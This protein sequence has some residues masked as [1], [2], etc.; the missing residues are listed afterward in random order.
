[1]TP[2]LPLGASLASLL[3][4]SVLL[5]IHDFG[6]VTLPCRFRVY[7]G[8]RNPISP[9]HIDVR[10]NFF[11]Q[12]T[13]CPCRLQTGLLLSVWMGIL[14]LLLAVGSLAASADPIVTLTVATRLTA[15]DGDAYDSFG[16]PV[17]IHE[18]LV[19]VGAS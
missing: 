7:A 6:K 19:A 15:P 4:L 5:C 18:K 9:Y 14:V 1:M 11:M 10:K 8:K 12:R 2:V 16:Y 3:L 17:A 13:H